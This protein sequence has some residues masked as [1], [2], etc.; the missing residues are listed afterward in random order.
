MA[1]IGV[2]VLIDIILDNHVDT[3]LDRKDL[4]SCDQGPG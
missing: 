4:R 1:R 3:V 2:C